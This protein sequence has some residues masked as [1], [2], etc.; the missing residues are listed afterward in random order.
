MGIFEPA[1]FILAQNFSRARSFRINYYNEIGG[2]QPFIVHCLIPKNTCPN[3][4]SKWYSLVSTKGKVAKLLYISLC[5]SI[6]Q[7]VSPS[8]ER[9]SIF[10]FSAPI[11]V[12][13]NW[14]FFVKVSSSK[15]IHIT[16]YFVCKSMGYVTKDI[17]IFLMNVS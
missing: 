15:E 2:L 9:T 14:F 4:A 12:K 10:V 16:T 8:D 3:T 6:R 1:R 11:K 7:S 17:Q 13:V 5:W